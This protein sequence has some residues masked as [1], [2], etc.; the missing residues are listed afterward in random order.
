M[1][2]GGQI[3]G[4]RRVWRGLTDSGRA[5]RHL[6]WVDGWMRWKARISSTLHLGGG[7]HESAWISQKSTSSPAWCRHRSHSP[8]FSAPR[9]GKN[10][11]FRPSDCRASR[12]S[13]L[14]SPCTYMPRGFISSSS[15][16][17]PPLFLAHPIFCLFLISSPQSPFEMTHR[18]LK[19]RERKRRK[20]GCEKKE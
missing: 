12:I 7:S 8:V 18:G 19:K 1:G 5:E 9:A 16:P 2:S 17:S 14:R 20:S 15:S 4:V 3:D 11:H 10:R 13:P 6:G